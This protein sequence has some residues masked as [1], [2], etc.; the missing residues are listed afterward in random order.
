VYL[1]LECIVSVHRT[2]TATDQT[3]TEH[4]QAV[5]KAYLYLYLKQL[6]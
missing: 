5:W 1:Y 6:S 2:V 4:V 3:K